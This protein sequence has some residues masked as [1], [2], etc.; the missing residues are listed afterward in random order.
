M[1]LLY[2][3]VQRTDYKTATYNYVYTSINIPEKRSAWAK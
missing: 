3:N 1:T 2:S